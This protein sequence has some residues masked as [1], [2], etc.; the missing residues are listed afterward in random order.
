VNCA[1]R[2]RSEAGRVKHRATDAD[3]RAGANKKPACSEQLRGSRGGTS[4]A[5][6]RWMRSS[7]PSLK[8]G[9][10]LKG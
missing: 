5:S 9:E 1:L 6:Q 3:S 10:E 2:A 7:S 8:A 4:A